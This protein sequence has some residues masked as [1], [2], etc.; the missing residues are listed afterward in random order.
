MTGNYGGISWNI[1]TPSRVKMDS[2]FKQCHDSDSVYFGLSQVINMTQTIAI[3]MV[4][5]WLPGSMTCDKSLFFFFFD[6][7]L[8]NVA[9][10]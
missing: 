4:R 3:I 5:S 7:D 9:N 8:F 10:S 2:M 6:V 1:K